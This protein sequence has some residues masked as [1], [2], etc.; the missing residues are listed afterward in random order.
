MAVTVILPILAGIT[1]GAMDLYIHNFQVTSLQNAADSA[2]LAAAR[3]ASLKGWNV[4]TAKAVADN[5]L[6]ETLAQVG[7]KQATYSNDVKVD[8]AKRRVLVTVT[9]D[10]YGYFFLGYFKGSPQISVTSVAQ[11]SGSTNVC[12]IGL[13]KTDPST[14]SLIDAAKISATDCAVYSNSVATGGMGSI[15]YAFLNA[16][17]ACTAGGYSGAARNFSQNPVTDCPAMSDPLAHRPPPSIS[18]SCKHRNLKIKKTKSPLV[19]RPGVYCG[20]LTIMQTATVFLTPGIYVIKDGPLVIAQNAVVTG[21]GVGFYFTG[22]KSAL[23]AKGGSI[24]NFSAPKSGPMAGLLMFQ[25]RSSREANFVIKSKRA[26]RLIGTI[27]LPNGNFVVKTKDK[28]AEESAYTAIVARRVIV[29]QSTDLVLNTNYD[30][31][32]VP[33]P[34]GVGPVGSTLRI[35]H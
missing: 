17:L 12:V 24:L 22:K 30:G 11:A 23:D 14:V 20:G 5:F 9:Q 6:S 31:T 33:V 7:M 26:A 28:I 15:D 21:I 8:T 10:H 16:R 13:E 29:Q 32:D 27:Y 2:V 19:L 25:D 4:R 34:D 3:E 1:G 18:A 35:V